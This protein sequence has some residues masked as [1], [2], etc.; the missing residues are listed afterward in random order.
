MPTFDDGS[1]QPDSLPEGGG[2]AH[3][4]DLGRSWSFQLT[5]GLDYVEL[6]MWDD[7]EPFASRLP[8]IKPLP[9]IEQQM[10]KAFWVAAWRILAQRHNRPV[11]PTRLGILPLTSNR[12][13]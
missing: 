6:R 7:K 9:E 10:A 3:L 8:R 12:E 4:L 5:V 11:I 1:P 13:E 2:F